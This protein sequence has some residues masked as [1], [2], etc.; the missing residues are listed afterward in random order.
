[1]SKSNK[2]DKMTKSAKSETKSAK[3]ETK[4]TKSAK[5]E[6]KS[7]TSVEDTY[8][9]VNDIEHILL[10]PD[11]YVG[12]IDTNNVEMWTLNSD[13]KFSK[14]EITFS[15][16]LYKIFDEILVN[17]R[18][19][20]VRNPKTCKTIKVDLDEVTG[21]ITVYNDGPGIPV[22]FHKDF[23][24][25]IPEMIFGHLRTSSNYTESGKLVGG[26]NGFGAKLA[27]VLS[28]EFQIETIDSDE[29]LHYKQLFQTNMSK[30]NPPV[31]TPSKEKSFTKISFIPEYERFGFKKMTLDIVTLFSKRVYDIAACTNKNVKVYLNETEIK[32][33][34][35]SDYIKLY[36]PEPP[37]T[38]VY[39]EITDRWK[40][41][42]IFNP[43]AGFSSVSFVN[44]IQTYNGGTHVKYICD[45][46]T[47]KL[48]EIILKKNKKVKIKPDQIK[49]NIT[50]FV[51]CS[52]EDPTFNSQVKDKLN[53]PKSAF[54]SVCDVPDDFVTK[55]AK[56]GIVDEVISIAEFKENKELKKSDGKKTKTLKDII[57]L[58]DAEDAGGP[59]SVNCRLIL[60]EGD[61]AK[62]FA[63]NGLEIIGSK[64]Y[65]VF[66]LRGKFLNVRNAPISTIAKNEEFIMFKRIMGLQQGKK[67]SSRKELRYGGILIL[68]DQDDDGSHIK[69]LLI[70]MIQFMWPE[71]ILQDNFIQCLKTPLIKT[72]K[73]SDKNNSEPKIFYTLSEYKAWSESLGDDLKKWSKPKYYK[74]LGTSTAYEAKETFLDFDRKQINFICADAD[75]DDDTNSDEVDVEEASD[76][77]PES[78]TKSITS[79][80]DKK[81]T[82]IDR[83]RLRRVN[84]IITLAFDKKRADD[85]KRWLS[86]YDSNDILEAVGDISYADFINKELIHFSNANNIRAIP[87][88][89]D[90]FKP[91]QRKIFFA[92][93]KRGRNAKEI[94]V[95]QFAGI[96]ATE[97][98]Y[99]HGEV[100]LMETIIGMAQNFPGSNNINI[101]L[102]NGNFGSRRQ[103]GADAASSR[104][105]FTNLNKISNKIFREEDEMI[106]EYKIEEGKEIEPINYEPIIPMVLVNGISGIGTG[107]STDIAPFNPLDLVKSL[108]K[109]IKGEICSEIYP[110]YRGYQGSILKIDDQHFLMKGVYR[111]VDSDT[112]HLTEIPTEF[113]LEGY[114]AFLTSL[115]IVEKKDTQIDTSKQKITDFIMKPYTNKVDV[116]ITFRP[117]ELQ[118]LIKEDKI[119][120]YLKLNS[121]ISLT[122]MHAYNHLN[123]MTKYDSPYEILEEFYTYR[124]GVYVKRKA[125]YIRVLENDLNLI[126]YK[127]M[128]I[129]NILDKKIII[130]RQRKEAIIE[131]LVSLKYPKLSSDIN[132][133]DKSY[134]Y[135]INL[136][137]W[138]LTFEKI[139]E[140][141][142]ELDTKKALLDAYL[143][144]TVEQIWLGELDEFEKTYNKWL[145]ELDE[146]Q[147]R[148]DKLALKTKV[149]SS[150]K[151]K[152]KAKK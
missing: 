47:A 84:N 36:Y 139:E 101:L 30:I 61:S 120:S 7:T 77:D 40:V 35:F 152:T 128:F 74:G 123:K 143:S 75:D 8:V 45:Q 19:H 16:A 50:L 116:M 28:T 142:L 102:P 93:T 130:E 98:E 63:L 149:K 9:H 22:K 85:R 138:S 72:F 20:S 122:N 117:T 148:E 58:D 5:S 104:Y 83:N 3:S 52:I 13:E 114:K 68:T 151:S 15:A 46:L 56:S 141:K 34:S 140:L 147:K 81:A 146:E 144:K 67:Y 4:T 64:L 18:D 106:L 97:T 39:E 27:N 88:Q 150:A 137:L 6:T 12:T 111:I 108:R 96:V 49:S 109:L 38:L 127:V 59:N 24:T 44:G 82:S 71:L 70:N 65:G 133:D 129:E 42:A 76:N 87:S 132:S 145:L 54:G 86:K 89:I 17:A 60:T 25:Y 41:G 73:T 90:G 79:N 110:F 29:K 23:G 91:G 32:L 126:K 80:V 14:S 124:L 121:K 78:D 2:S 21:R 105:I 10:R 66:P 57:K 103:K 118:K 26:K 1:M 55:F 135:L 125:F 134:S 107:F 31:I 33:Q 115:E 62:G 11:M 53:T 95:A 94:K 69:G 113:S 119:E 37:K 48:T 131:K 99:H 43:D 112:V 136:P 92:A 100:S 51:E